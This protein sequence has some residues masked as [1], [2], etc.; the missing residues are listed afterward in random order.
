MEVTKPCGS[1]C[2]DRSQLIL[3][4]HVWQCTIVTRSRPEHT[5]G[6]FPKNLTEQNFHI[7]LSFSMYKA[8]KQDSVW[9]TATM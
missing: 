4:D 9:S 8:N 6:V 1:I 3:I 5:V 7:L 2:E